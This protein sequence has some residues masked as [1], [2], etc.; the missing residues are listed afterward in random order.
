MTDEPTQRFTRLVLFQ[1]QQD[2]AQELIIAAVVSEGSAVRYKVGDTW[3][4]MSPPP[5]R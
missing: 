3:Y 2:H 1:A 4:D 5:A